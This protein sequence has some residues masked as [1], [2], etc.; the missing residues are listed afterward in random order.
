M[1]APRASL[2]ARKRLSPLAFLKSLYSVRACHESAAVPQPYHVSIAKFSLMKV[3]LFVTGSGGL[4]AAWL[5]A[6]FFAAVPVSSYPQLGR[7]SVPLSVAQIHPASPV[8]ESVS[9]PPAKLL[10]KTGAAALQEAA[11][12]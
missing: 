5:G 8:A 7:G 12:H 4:L 1:K 11:A 2:A 9:L 6:T 3:K 10:A